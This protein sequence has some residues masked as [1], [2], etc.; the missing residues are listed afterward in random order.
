[1]ERI[2][3]RR[4][5]FEKWT[6]G[7]WLASLGG[8][9]VALSL[10]CVPWVRQNALDAVSLPAGF[11]MALF[12]AWVSERARRRERDAQINKIRDFHFND[13]AMGLHNASATIGENILFVYATLYEFYL[14]NFTTV[15]IKPDHIAL[16]TP[17]I[18]AGKIAENMKHMERQCDKLLKDM[19][20]HNFRNEFVI[21]KRD[22]LDLISDLK[23]AFKIL[24]Q[25]SWIHDY[26]TTDAM[27]RSRFK[28]VE[29][30]F[31]E[32]VCRPIEEIQDNCEK[33]K[34]IKEGEVSLF[35]IN[36]VETLKNAKKY[37]DENFKK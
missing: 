10:L 37:L 11:F 36:I 31:K 6:L 19:K 32:L 7:L 16:D 29:N 15:L 33:L 25:T 2:K 14:G 27:V 20:E 3:S 35:E 4:G 12:L 8:V 18:A 30:A 1:V 9:I 26:A 34:I 28:T 23:I 17:Q 22:E 5:K 24:G 13:F 21:F